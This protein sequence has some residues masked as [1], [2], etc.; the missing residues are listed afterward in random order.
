MSSNNAKSPRS[1]PTLD[2]G[3]DVAVV[4]VKDSEWW[5]GV[6]KPSEREN[7]DAVENSSKVIML[8]HILAYSD[9]IGDKVLVFSQCLKTLDFVEHVMQLEDWTSHVK[10]LKKHFPGQKLGGWK[11]DIDFL[12]IDGQTASGK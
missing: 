4:S 7:L 10:S 6:L 11:R 12:R 9:K 3:E 5:T 1:S 2:E 8:L